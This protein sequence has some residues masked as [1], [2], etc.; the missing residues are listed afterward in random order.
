MTFN[1]TRSI[2]TRKEIEK[3]PGV[4]VYHSYCDKRAGNENRHK[5]YIE[6]DYNSKL[7]L[8]KIQ[9]IIKN[10]FPESFPQLYKG[11]VYE[12]KAARI[13]IVW[14]SSREM[15]VDEAF[16]VIIEDTGTMLEAAE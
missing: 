14:R 7:N 15:Y 1:A 8:R 2:R 3:L 13:Q 6:I 11:N 12:D 16:K 4:K 5:W 9:L 10:N